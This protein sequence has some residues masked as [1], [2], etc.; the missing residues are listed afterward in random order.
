M[1]MATQIQHVWTEAGTHLVQSTGHI[2]N[3]A[4]DWRLEVDNGDPATRTQQAP[5]V[6]QNTGAA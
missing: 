3:N 2:P 5:E 1:C 4:P 6:A